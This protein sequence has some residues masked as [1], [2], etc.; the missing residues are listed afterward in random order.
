MT[1]RAWAA[2][3]LALAAGCGDSHSGNEGN[4]LYPANYNSSLDPFNENTLTTYGLRMEPSD[5]DA[6]V[7]DPFNRTWRRAVLEWEGEVWND[8]AVRAAGQRS[9]IPGNPKPSI[10]IKFNFFVPERKFHSRFLTGVRL[11]SDTND[12]SMMRRRLE[13]GIYRA[14][15]LPAPRCVHAR[16][17]V[18]DATKGLYQVEERL[19]RGFV[20][21][22]FSD[23]RINQMYEFLP[24]AEAFAGHNDDVTWAGPDPALYVPHLFVPQLRE[25]D[26]ANP[27]LKVAFPEE[28][29]DFVE[30]VNTR[31]WSAIARAVHI[32][33]FCRFMAAEVATGEADGYVAFRVSGFPPFRSSNFRIYPD[34]VSGKWVVLAWDREEGY[35]ATRESITTGF[36]QR[37]LTKNLILADPGTLARYREILERLVRGPASVEAMNARIDR[38]VDQVRDAAAED[39]FKTAGSTENWF[40]H[41]QTIRDFIAVHNAMIT[42]ELSR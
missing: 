34:P 28:V 39:P 13:D 35:W 36:D 41:V 2:V 32:E 4:G 12:P 42:S 3:V 20:K 33:H 15:G 18:N 17:V 9:R 23:S 24:D 16:V 19:N 31:P 8:V 30:T 6:I 40:A 26:P 14:T 25:L 1:G 21:E 5:W 38:I 29:R 27:D 7:A 11:T 22:H 10:R 37:V